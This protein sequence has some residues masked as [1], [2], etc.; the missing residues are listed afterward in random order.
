MFSVWGNGCNIRPK[1]GTRKRIEQ[2]V[3]P[4]WRKRSEKRKKTPPVYRQ[5]LA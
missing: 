1:G 5:R 4:G 2:H 3:A